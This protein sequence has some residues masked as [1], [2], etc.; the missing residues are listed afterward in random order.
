MKKQ[1]NIYQTLSNKELNLDNL[2]KKELGLYNQVKEF[3]ESKPSWNAFGNYWIKELNNTFKQK[4]RKDR[5]K[6]TNQDIWRI[7]IDLESRLGIEQGY[8]RKS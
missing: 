6:I 5:E 2:T 1:K 7:C 4:S 8:V 3:Y